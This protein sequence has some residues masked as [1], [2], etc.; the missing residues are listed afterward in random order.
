MGSTDAGKG[1]VAGR[2]ERRLWLGAVGGVAE[3]AV[4]GALWALFDPL[5]TGHGVE[6]QAIWVRLWGWG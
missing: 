6:P 1:V 4:D 5:F 2:L 3:E